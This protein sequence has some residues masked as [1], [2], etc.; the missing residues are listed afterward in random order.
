MYVISTIHSY[1]VYI[2]NS[3]LLCFVQVKSSIIGQ[4]VGFT[5]NVRQMAG[6]IGLQIVGFE[7]EKERL[8]ISMG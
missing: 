4:I 8:G 1:Q 5:Q 2:D 7:G 3:Q 6:W